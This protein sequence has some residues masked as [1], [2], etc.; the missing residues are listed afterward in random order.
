MLGAIAR[1]RSGEDIRLTAVITEVNTVSPEFRYESSFLFRF[2]LLRHIVRPNTYLNILSTQVPFFSTHFP[3][4]FVTIATV[5][6]TSSFAASQ[7]CINTVDSTECFIRSIYAGIISWQIDGEK[8][9]NSLSCQLA[10]EPN[11]LVN[12]IEPA[13]NLVVVFTI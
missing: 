13:Y 6:I 5:A 9:R 10:C 3:T 7:I 12:L 4:I 8:I 2:R 1:T 11:G